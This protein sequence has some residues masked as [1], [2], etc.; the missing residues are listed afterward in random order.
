MGVAAQV[1]FYLFILFSSIFISS[2]S[3]SEDDFVY[4][5]YIRTSKKIKA[6]TDSIISFN[7][8]R[9]RRIWY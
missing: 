2:I 3:G 4:T 5:V 6:G 9:C 1:W 7:S 8:L